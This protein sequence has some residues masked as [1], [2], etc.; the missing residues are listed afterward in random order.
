MIDIQ[1]DL[2]FSVHDPLTGDDPVTGTVTANGK[3]VQV[4]ADTLPTVSIRS[5]AGLARRVSRSLAVRG[6]TV[7][8]SGPDGAVASIG[9]VKAGLLSRVL[10]RSGAIRLHDLRTVVRMAL[11]R[12]GGGLPLAD[13]IP[14][15]VLWPIAPTF[16]GRKPP[17]S[18]T[19]D[20]DGGGRPRL[21][22]PAGEI[23]APGQ[24][25]EVYFLKQGVTTI[26]S[27]PECDL[28]LA[29]LAD[30]QAEVR[31]TSGDEYVLVPISRTVP[32]RVNGRPLTA[33]E[34]LE[35]VLRTGTRV[36]LGSWAMT[37]FR[38]EY[39]DHGRPYGG[40]VG[41]EAG[42][43]QSQVVPTYREPPPRG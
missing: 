16:S 22:F 39:A 8:L 15:S 2:T 43:Q 36:A 5:S 9:A 23:S 11:R 17:I 14:P 41:G 28:Q 4:H 7:E 31:R 10:T 40:R 12:S 34:T 35:G 1:A 29:G 3:L 32:S 25:G 27:G 37:Y 24:I 19:H 20:P 26:G 18:T 42:Y 21:L 33:G 13:L 38:E 6:I 30:L